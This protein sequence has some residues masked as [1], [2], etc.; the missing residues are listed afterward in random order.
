MKRL[1][2]FLCLLVPFASFSADYPQR[3][4]GLWEIQNSMEGMPAGQT[5]RQC[6]NPEMDKKM[7][8]MGS[9]MNEQ[10]GADCSKVEFRKEGKNYVSETDCNMGGMRMISKSVFSGDFNKNYTGVTTVSFE[11]PVMGMKNQ[12]MKQTARWVGACEPGQKP[13]DIIMPNGQKLNINSMG[14]MGGA[15]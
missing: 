7:I 14:A 3:K 1:S 6:V 11:P 13:G 5:I 12:K 2:I 9:N 10:M 4:A 8:E 15:R